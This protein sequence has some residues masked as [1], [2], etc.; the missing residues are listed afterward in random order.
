MFMVVC[1]DVVDDKKRTRL[2]KIMVNYG[3]R[4]QKSVFE[5]ELDDRM[6]LR[7]KDAVEKVIDWEEDSV[8]YYVLCKNCKGN[9][10]V[11][12][13]GVLREEEEEVIVV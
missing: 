5:C 12:G 8:R 13:T 10:T 2:A 9:V 4:V 7:M 6:F 1:Y 3:R 11:S